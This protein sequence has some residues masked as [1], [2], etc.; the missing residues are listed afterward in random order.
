[1]TLAT[2]EADGRSPSR[3][4]HFAAR[5]PKAVAVVLTA[6]A[7]AVAVSI[8]V[9]VTP[10]APAKAP[11][12]P[13]PVSGVPSTITVEALAGPP[14]DVAEAVDTKHMLQDLMTKAGLRP[15]FG[16]R[17]L[18]WDQARKLNALMPKAK[19]EVDP[20]R[21]F[22][23]A[24]DTKNGREALHCLTQAAYYEA[25][26]NG[27]EA[28]AAVA[29]VVLNRVRDPDFPKSVCGVVYQGAERDSGCQFTFTCD[30]AL[31]RPL[32]K[33][34]WSEAQKVAARALSGYVVKT[35]GASTYYHADY[36]FPTWAPTLDKIAKVG[37]HIFYSVAG[38]EGSLLTGHYA[39]GELKLARA[40]LDA[41][42]RFLPKA[43]AK[44]AA[45]APL[46]VASLQTSG[47]QTPVTLAP[48]GL[49]MQAERLQRVHD[50]MA[51][52]HDP[53]AEVHAADQS[54]MAPAKPAAA[55]VATPDAAKPSPAPVQTADV[56]APAA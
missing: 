47:V 10:A 25:G 42:D 11:V 24:I 31:A 20:V 40:M 5:H 23:I 34:A 29:Q 1:M 54:I 44:K 35:V 45:D 19:V 21:P 18:T 56:Q 4:E 16:L 52:T 49:R 7:A 43:Q 8:G 39:G 53:M 27:P 9:A 12:P 30:G 15:D 50:V 33:A 46:Q 2:L 6:G 32:D 14:A 28:E 26:G 17:H 13:P 36:V 51:G 55:P 22:S 3:V 37:P 41:A 48:A 38:P